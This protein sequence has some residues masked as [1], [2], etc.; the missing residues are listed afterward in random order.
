[1]VIAV[2]LYIALQVAFIAALDPSS[3]SKGWSA[4]TLSGKAQVF[5]PFAGLATALGLGW[6]AVLIYSDAIVSPGGTGLLYTGASSRLSFA[7]GRNGYIPRRSPCSP[8]GTPRFAIAFSFPCGLVLFLPFPGWQQLVG[9]I[10]SAAVLA[11][12]M[13]PLSLAALR[14]EDPA[15]PRPFRLPVAGFVAPAVRRRERDPVLTGWAVDWKLIVAILIGFALLTPR[16]RRTRT[17]GRS[18]S[19]GAAP[20]GSGRTCSASP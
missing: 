19:T 6:L 10:S 5:G 7:L 12:A 8:G 20:S 4:I 2:G 18:R 3:L 14:R 17:R 1:M 16:S 11:Y 13:V 15:R 9:F